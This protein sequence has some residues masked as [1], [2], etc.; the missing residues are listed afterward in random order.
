MAKPG[1]RGVAAGDGQE[2]AG[3]HRAT[4]GRSRGPAPVQPRA[5]TLGHGMRPHKLADAAVAEERQPCQGDD[6]VCQRWAIWPAR[7]AANCS[8]PAMSS[9]P[10]ARTRW[11]PVAGTLVASN[12][13][14]LRSTMGKS[15][16]PAAADAGSGAASAT[17]SGEGGQSRS[18]QH[19]GAE[20]EGD[21]PLNKENMSVRLDVTRRESSAVGAPLP[22][23]GRGRCRFDNRRFPGA[24]RPPPH[25]HSLETH[26]PQ[27][28]RQSSICC[29]AGLQTA[30]YGQASVGSTTW[31]SRPG[32]YPVPRTGSC[33]PSGVSSAS[34]R[35]I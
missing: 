6:Q 18:D 14:S 32:G 5:G 34:V 9:S 30:P 12:N 29:V 13:L 17:R 15:S 8:A 27:D 7:H 24:S 23:R 16:R 20:T 28:A 11:T 21:S 35:R 26:R 10:H 22:D 1:S 4:H 3:E 19:H 31:N 25:I 2:P 33:R